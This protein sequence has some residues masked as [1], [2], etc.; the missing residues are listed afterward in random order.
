[1]RIKAVVA[2]DGSSFEGFQEQKR[3][4]NT[5]AFA[6]KKALKSVGIY[7]DITGSG[8]T[9]SHVH[10]TAQ[11]IHFDLPKYWESKTDSLKEALNGKVDA[12]Y[13]RHIVEVPDSFHARYSAKERVY[14][15]I[16][17]QNPSVFERKYV[18]DI[19]IKDYTRLKE[20]LG[21][22]EGEHNFGYF[23]KSGSDVKS[24][25]REIYKAF[26]IKRGKY[27]I[28]YFSANGFL[29]SQVRLMVSASIAYANGDISLKQ[30]ANQIKATDRYITKPAPPYGLYLCGVRY[31]KI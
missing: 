11:V 13:F 8:R 19:T 24:T 1:M 14:R 29:R 31:P 26:Y 22:F 2:Y 9:D 10:A 30:L 17:C 18:S 23:C 7:S 27:S 15:Y 3:T 25:I 28:I 4:A 12:I 16:I 21:I 20:A 5:V 6:I